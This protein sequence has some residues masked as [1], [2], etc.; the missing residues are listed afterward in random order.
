MNRTTQIA[1]AES[2]GALHVKGVP[3][4]LF[5]I[6]DAASAGAVARSGAAALATSSFAVAHARGD[7]DGENLCFDKLIAVVSEI[8]HTVDLPLTVDI[9]TGYGDTPQAVAASVT[10]VIEAGGIG[11]NLEDGLVGRQGIRSVPEQC[12]R[13]E[14]ARRAAADTGIPI[15]INARCDLFNGVPVERQTG[16]ML[17]LMLERATAYAGAGASGFFIPWLTSPKL[18]GALCAEAP[19]PVNI[20]GDPA[21]PSADELASLGVSRISLGAW[22]I[23]GMLAKLEVA[24]KTWLVTGIVAPA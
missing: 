1:H 22:P 7:G 9:E 2:F 20:L 3:L 14:A 13:I 6:W 15:F 21:A 11:V 19:V 17:P 23:F 5:N 10:R 16:D 4:R 8:A 12:A 18:I 24:A